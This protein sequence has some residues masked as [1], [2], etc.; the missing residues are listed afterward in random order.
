MFVLAVDPGYPGGWSVVGKSDAGLKVEFSGKPPAFTVVKNKRRRTEINGPEINRLVREFKERYVPLYA[1]LEDTH[2]F[3]KDGKVG[4]FRFGWI[5]GF[6]ESLFQSH[7]IP[8]HLISPHTWRS[9]CL[10]SVRAVDKS[11]S[12]VKAKQLF[13]N[14][15]DEDHNIAE[16]L[17]MAYTFF[18]K[19]HQA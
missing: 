17:L 12:V 5:K 6:W 8:Y 13:P 15:I 7:E 9:F 4:A 14:F 10:G 19:I 3:P 16:S 1:C 11:Q 2:A 18:G